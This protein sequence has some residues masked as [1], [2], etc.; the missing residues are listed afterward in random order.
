MSN[1]IK[2]VDKIQS[3]IT[4][5]VQEQL[6]N[7]LH[8]N[9]GSFIA[10]VIDLYSSDPY[11]QQC[12]ASA[13]VMECMKAASL[14]LPINKQLGFA[15]VVPYRSKGRLVPQF[16]MGY[17]GY[18]QLAMRSGQYRYLNAGIIYDGEEVVEDRLTGK[19]EI[20][21]QKKSDKPIGYFAYMELM[22]GFSKTVY[23]S[24][25]EI[26]AHAK[27]FSK[28]Y[29]SE[30]SPWK[31]SFDTMALKTVLKKLISKYGIMSIE[32]TEAM[33]YDLG[34]DAEITEVNE[35][36]ET[37]ANSQ[38]LVIDAKFEQKLIQEE[39]E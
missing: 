31:T 8:D 7:V 13:V 37:E 39:P 6:Y 12:E 38:P 33:T 32:M 4:V 15:Y 3:A 19:I 14:K 17:K 26:E 28:S 22:N 25:E 18:I 20:H 10:S 34:A 5:D 29:E 36:I 9:A 30:S 24:R 1:A 16:Q 11:L 23:M 35:V 2:P 21:G 27:R